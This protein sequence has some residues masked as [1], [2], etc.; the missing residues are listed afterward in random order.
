MQEGFPGSPQPAPPQPVKTPTP[1]GPSPVVQRFGETWVP[2]NRWS[3]ANALPAPV[4]QALTPLP[5]YAINTTNG[6]L[7]LKAGTRTAHWDGLDV[8][9]GFTPQLVDG[10]P[11]VHFLDL[12]KT[13]QPLLTG[14]GAGPLSRVRTGAAP[15]I[16]IDPGHGGENAGTRSAVGP[17]FEKDFTL[18]W[19]RR[20]QVR[21]QAQ[22][23][24]AFLTRTND[25]DVPISNRVAFA[26]EL[27]ADL[28]VSLH[29]NS[30]APNDGQVGLETYCVTPTGMPSTVKRQFEDDP[31]EILPNNAFDIENLRLA[32]CVH[33]AL[34]QINGHR[35]RGVRRAR[36]PGV[37]RGQ[38]R[39]AVL[40]EG[41][42]LSN[43]EEARRIAEPQYRQKL[44]EAVAQALGAAN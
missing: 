15:V 11:F 30:S 21:L 43:P 14:Y 22:G 31:T 6:T 8:R 27:A 12:N 23:W 19:A 1:A 41:G 25:S 29:F 9:L 34:L 35:D 40:I 42:Y 44:A 17:H 5:T 13:I 24:R 3:R 16:V 4:C 39:P 26:Q 10:Q 18:D 38:Q 2:L 7:V 32:L 20:L 37:L 36:F 33:R 28:F